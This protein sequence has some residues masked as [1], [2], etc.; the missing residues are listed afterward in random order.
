MLERID[1]GLE[2][3]DVGPRPVE[4]PGQMTLQRFDIFGI[5]TAIGQRHVQRRALLLEGEV[6]RPVHREREDALVAGEDRG[7]AISLVHVEVHHQ[8]ALDQ[9]FALQRACGDGDVVE[10]AKAASAVGGGV[11]RASGEIAGDSLPE[12]DEGGGHGAEDAR[13]R[14]RDQ[15][16]A[17]GEPE[18]AL[19]RG[20]KCSGE[21][22]VQVLGGV[23][24]E[25]R[26]P[27]DQSRFLQL[28]RRQH[29]L[30]N[31]T[32]PQQPVLRHREAVPRWKWQLVR[33]A[34]EGAHCRSLTGP[35]VG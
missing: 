10:D 28:V 8:H 15:R 29:A 35:A 14:S 4:N 33:V 11:V 26:C 19:L 24:E 2:E 27:V 32:F 16:F 20:R 17:P 30:G 1:A 9:S 34:E 3:E 22:R 6:L 23:G 5:A 18:P 21:D 13:P 31:Q 12:R 25:Q 7:R